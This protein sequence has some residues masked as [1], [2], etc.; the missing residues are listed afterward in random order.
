MEKI[1]IKIETDIEGL[2]ILKNSLNV[3]IKLLQDNIKG[4]NPCTKMGYELINSLHKELEIKQ[5]LLIEVEKQ[6]TVVA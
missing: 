1:T 2:E 5:N 6:L 4:S 3:E